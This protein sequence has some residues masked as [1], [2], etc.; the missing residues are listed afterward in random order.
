MAGRGEVC[1]KEVVEDDAGPLAA[2]PFIYLSF[3]YNEDI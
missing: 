2:S 3:G 1:S